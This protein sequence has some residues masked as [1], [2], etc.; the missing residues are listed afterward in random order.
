LQITRDGL[1]RTGRKLDVFFSIEAELY[2]NKM[3]QAQI[4]EIINDPEAGEPLDKLRLFMCYYLSIDSREEL[5]IE[6]FV[7]LLTACGADV[8]ALQHIKAVRQIEKMGDL[9]ATTTQPEQASFSNIFK[10]RLKGVGLS[11]SA[12]AVLAGLQSWR[13]PNTTRSLAQLCE[14][15]MDPSAASKA[16][17]STAQDLLLY[18]PYI[19][20]RDLP[21]QRS[22]G[23]TE[24][25]VFI[26]GGGSMDEAHSIQTI[27]QRGHGAK[28]ICY[29]ST[30]LLS[31]NEFVAE[32]TKL[33][34]EA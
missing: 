27:A 13:P 20:A 11:V 18:D 9:S 19:S 26:M 7:P 25:V 16:A 32:L 10:D 12:D 21:A 8:S 29:G 31:P 1:T 22:G 30:G 33:G 2:K 17:L 5:E 15:L 6:K 24:A 34:K 23:F 14:A 3:S 4:I 28:K